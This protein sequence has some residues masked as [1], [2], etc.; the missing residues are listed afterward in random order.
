MYSPV[1]V[2]DELKKISFF[3]VRGDEHY[4]LLKQ[5]KICINA[6]FIPLYYLME[7]IKKAEEDRLYLFLRFD[8]KERVFYLTWSRPKRR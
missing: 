4:I 5:D 1:D 7:I 6:S 2:L 3:Q 8:E